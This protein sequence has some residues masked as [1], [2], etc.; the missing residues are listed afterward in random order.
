MDE[1]LQSYLVINVTGLVQFGKK[2]SY[3]LPP[4]ASQNYQLQNISVKLIYQ[5]SHLIYGYFFFRYL[6]KVFEEE[7][8]K[9]NDKTSGGLTTRQLPQER[10]G[11]MKFLA[12]ILYLLARITLTLISSSAITGCFKKVNSDAVVW[13]CSLKKLF[14]KMS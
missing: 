7:R 11:K 8:N 1:L 13:R 4:L 9:N 5:F 6:E 14:L 12:L 10:I 3:I 2:L